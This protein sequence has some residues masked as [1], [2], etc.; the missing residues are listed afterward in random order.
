MAENVAIMKVIAVKNM[1]FTGSDGH[2]VKMNKVSFLL[3]DGD[4]GSLTTREQVKAGENCAIGF[5]CKD[6]KLYAKIVGVSR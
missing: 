4:V 5:G 6:G 1:E 3:A 2:P